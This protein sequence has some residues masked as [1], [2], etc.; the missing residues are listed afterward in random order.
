MNNAVLIWNMFAKFAE[1]NL[2][3]ERKKKKIMDGQAQK[4]IYRTN[5][6]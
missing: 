3:K 1:E 4:M 2:E 5:V 6:E